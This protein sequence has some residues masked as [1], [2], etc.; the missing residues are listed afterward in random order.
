MLG[1]SS[2]AL[3]LRMCY[4]NWIANRRPH[5]ASAFAHAVLGPASHAFD[6]AL[7]LQHLSP[8]APS[9]STQGAMP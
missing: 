5:A 9:S 2:E 8:A 6:N 7:P 4:A 3:G 1:A